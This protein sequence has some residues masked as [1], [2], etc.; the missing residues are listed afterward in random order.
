VAAEE[1]DRVSD[2]GRNPPPPGRGMGERAPQ[3]PQ[4]QGQ[5]DSSAEHGRL[6]RRIAGQVAREREQAARQKGRGPLAHEVLR[7]QVGEEAGQRDLKER[8]D[9]EPVQAG[10]HIAPGQ[11]QPDHQVADGIEDRGLDV[12]Q[13][14]VPREGVRVPNRQPACQNLGALK[15]T[16]RQE[17]IREVAGRKP[18][19]AEQDGSI[20]GRGE[21]QITK[22]SDQIVAPVGGDRP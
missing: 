11:F 14:R 18:A 8:L 21:G 1:G 12:C 4:D 10:H 19:Q 3:A 15:Q 9:L 5:P 22:Q 2:C 20:K 7:K 17:V 16:E 6:Q 13:E